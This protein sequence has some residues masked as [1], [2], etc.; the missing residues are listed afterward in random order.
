MPSCDLA[1]IFH[2]EW[3]QQSGNHSTDVYVA[4][5]DDCIKAFI[6]DMNYHQFIQGQSSK[7]RSREGESPTKGC[8]TF[9]PMLR[10]S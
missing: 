4:T 1:E 5:M 2:N 3:L 7:H 8:L 9:K 6:Y 10:K